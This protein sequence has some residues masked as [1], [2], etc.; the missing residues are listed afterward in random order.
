VKQGVSIGG[1]GEFLYQNFDRSLE[2]G[3][4]S[5]ETDSADLVRLVLYTGYKFNDRILFNSEIEYEHAT[6]GEGDEEKGE[7]SV[8]FAYLDFLFGERMGVRSGLV[9]VPVGF[10]NEL[11]EPPIYLGARRPE[12]EKNILP[13]TWRANGAGIHGEFGSGLSYRAYVT[14]SFRGVAS[15][16]EGIEG[17]T[18]DKGSHDLSATVDFAVC[19]AE[20]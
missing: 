8:E 18:A 13:S 15:P 2:D 4:P 10:L 9:L 11:H 16:D 3:T 5:G 17:F 14:E 7:V 12:V 6:T 19:T 20:T 1:Y